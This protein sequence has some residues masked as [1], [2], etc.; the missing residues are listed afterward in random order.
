MF[1]WWSLPHRQF[2]CE[3]SSNASRKNPG[4]ASSLGVPNS[5]EPGNANPRRWEHSSQA[6]NGGPG[7][8][9]RHR[10]SHS[11]LSASHQ[12]GMTTDPTAPVDT[13]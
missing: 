1:A 2:H 3:L 11:I 6:D 8:A 9:V 12:M 7:T 5:I 13:A 10:V 4:P